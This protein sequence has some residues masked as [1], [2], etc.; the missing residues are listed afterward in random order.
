MSKSSKSCGHTGQMHVMN[1]VN[2]AKERYESNRAKSYSMDSANL[3]RHPKH[4][5]VYPEIQAEANS[6]TK[7][8]CK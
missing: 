7:C 8:T 1:K 5:V 2:G 4:A 6:Q 3:E